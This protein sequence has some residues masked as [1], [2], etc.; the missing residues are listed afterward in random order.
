[1]SGGDAHGGAA[2]RSKNSRLHDGRIGTWAAQQLGDLG[3]DAT[4]SSR[5]RATPRASS[6]RHAIRAWPP[7]ISAAIAPSARSC[8]ISRRRRPQGAVQTGPR[9]PTC[10]LE[11]SFRPRAAAG[12]DSEAF[13]KIN[14]RRRLLTDHGYRVAGPMGSKAAYDDI[15]QAGLGPPPRGRPW[16]AGH[17]ALPADDRG[18]Q[19]LSTP[20]SRRAR[21]AV[22]TRWEDGEGQ[23]GQGA[24][25]PDA[26]LRIRHGRAS[27]CR[28]LP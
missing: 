5:P 4:R 27:L 26:A 17:P 19:D 25:V 6:G 22:L 21:W 3:A 28:D 14:P 8:S 1:M 24:D 2:G 12:R 7:S 18:R 10:R 23:A 13:E 9:P 11:L 20:C 16:Y 15:I